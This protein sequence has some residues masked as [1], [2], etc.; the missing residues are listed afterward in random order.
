MARPMPREPP[1]TSAVRPVRSNGRY[2]LP[3]T[4]PSICRVLIDA[5][6]VRGGEL[7]SSIP[8]GPQPCWRDSSMASQPVSERIEDTPILRPLRSAA[9]RMSLSGCTRMTR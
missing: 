7:T 4:M 3:V 8:R 9:E 6:E 1:V 5:S 2:S